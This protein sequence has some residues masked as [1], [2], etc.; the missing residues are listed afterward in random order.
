[1]ENKTRNI[2]LNLAL[3]LLGIPI[4]SL[5]VLVTITLIGALD[6]LITKIQLTGYWWVML[7][8]MYLLSLVYTLYEPVF[9]KNR[10]R[11]RIANA[12][13]LYLNDQMQKQDKSYPI[14]KNSEMIKEMLLERFKIWAWQD[15][16]L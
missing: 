4:V 11:N 10:E 8:P 12:L 14:T 15:P 16:K 5:V 6:D 1:M 9:R 7:I 13:M 3:A 2:W